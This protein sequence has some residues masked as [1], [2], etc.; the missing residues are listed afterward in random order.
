MAVSVAAYS[1]IL[2]LLVLQTS[3]ATVMPLEAICVGSNRILAFLL[4]EDKEEATNHEAAVAICNRVTEGRLAL[5]A[6]GATADAVLKLVEV[7]IS[8]VIRSL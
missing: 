2:L 1:A 7:R 4:P 3:Y 8:S 5:I 6:T